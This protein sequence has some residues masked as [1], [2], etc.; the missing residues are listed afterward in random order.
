MICF[1]FEIG[2]KSGKLVDVLRAT[3]T[4]DDHTP[5]GI[6]GGHNYE[7]AERA[8]VHRAIVVFK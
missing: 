4:V 3:N 7:G 6:T 8:D 5:S 2:G 1:H